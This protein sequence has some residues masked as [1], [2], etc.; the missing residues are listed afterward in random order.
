M[1]LCAGRY[2]VRL[3]DEERYSPGSTDNVR[4]YD[5]EHR[6]DDEHFGSMHGVECTGGDQ[7]HS[8]I[9]MASGGKTAVHG[10]SVVVVGERLFVACGDSVFA[11]A[12]PSLSLEWGAQSRLGDVLRHLLRMRARLPRLARRVRDLTPESR[13]PRGVE[14]EPVRDLHRGVPVVV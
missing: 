10:H 11:L 9:L 6:T 7:K 4:S 13:R 3:I 1:E 14:S 2:V 5:A 8:C 12:I